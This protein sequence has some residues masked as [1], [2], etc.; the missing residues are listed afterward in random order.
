M[1]SRHESLSELRDGEIVGP[2][3]EERDGE[4]GD[5]DD[6]REEGEVEDVRVITTGLGGRGRR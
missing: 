3:P 1:G 6:G 5:E 4:E 2:T